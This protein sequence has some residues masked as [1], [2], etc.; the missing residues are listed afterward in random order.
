MGRP[1]TNL[2]A[3]LQSLELHRDFI[4]DVMVPLAAASIAAGGV[5]VAAVVTGLFIVAE[6]RASQRAASEHSQQREKPARQK[7]AQISKETIVHVAAAPE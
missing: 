7:E 2:E 6:R 5:I 1:N 4:L 3:L